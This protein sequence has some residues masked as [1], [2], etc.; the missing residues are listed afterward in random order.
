MA[1]TDQERMA[2]M[3][4]ALRKLVLQYTPGCDV[5]HDQL[6][7]GPTVSTALRNCLDAVY[8]DFLVCIANANTCE[9]EQ[10]CRD[11]YEAAV[12]ACYDLYG[13]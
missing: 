13:G 10:D 1:K 4:A 11:A 3:G 6:P 9:D 12:Q 8:Y 5:D 2:D 7:I